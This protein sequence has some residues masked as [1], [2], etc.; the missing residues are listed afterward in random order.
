[1]TFMGYYCLFMGR[2]LCNCVFYGACSFYGDAYSGIAWEAE[3]TAGLA[4]SDEKGRYHGRYRGIYGLSK[5]GFRQ[6]FRRRK[7][8]I[9]YFMLLMAS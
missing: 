2:G 7:P 8:Q 6:G 4:V 3:I 1:M 9:A 5:T